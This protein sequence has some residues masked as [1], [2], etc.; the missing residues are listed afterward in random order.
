MHEVM[1]KSFVYEQIQKKTDGRENKI[2]VLY[3]YK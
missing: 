1:E 3:V 2:W